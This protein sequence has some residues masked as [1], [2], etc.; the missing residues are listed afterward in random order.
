MLGPHTRI[1]RIYGCV[2]YGSVG[3][4]HL[5]SSTWC[6][7]GLSGGSGRM[8]PCPRPSPSRRLAWLD[9]E[10][11]EWQAD[12]LI[13]SDEARAIRVPLRRLPAAAADPGGA[14]PR[15]G[16][17]R[18]RCDLVG[19]G[20]SRPDPPDGAAGRCR[21]RSG[22]DWWPWPRCSHAAPEHGRERPRLADG[23]RGTVA[24]GG[25]VRRHRL[26]GGAEPAG[27]RLLP[28]AGGLVGR[29][30]DALRLCRR[31]GWR[32]WPSRSWSARSGSSG[33]AWTSRSPA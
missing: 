19:G 17:R 14:R 31:S 16:V 10:L 26:P 12:G 7:A 2:T 25:G 13:A 21:S 5:E 8:W 24:G 27:A 3:M 22:W 11:K 33:R 20:Q 29:R 32:R 15:S 23:R 28:V 1:D 6:G 18:H 9:G 30:G 4:R